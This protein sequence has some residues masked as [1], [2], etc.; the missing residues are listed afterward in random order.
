[1]VFPTIHKGKCASRTKTIPQV[2]VIGS[3][4][5]ACL[6][7]ATVSLLAAAATARAAY[8]AKLERVNQEMDALHIS[9]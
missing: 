9:L 2:T 3:L 1:M 5:F 4:M 8:S 7:A 6:I